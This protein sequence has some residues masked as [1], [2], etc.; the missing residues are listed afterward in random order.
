MKSNKAFW[1]ITF[2]CC[3]V[4][5][6]ASDLS[7]SKV[8]KILKKSWQYYVKTK[9]LPDGR[10]LADIDLQNLSNGSYGKELTFSESVSYILFRAVLADDQQTFNQTW[11][12]TATHLWRRNLRQVF[13]WK[14]SRWVQLPDEKRDNLF[15]WRYTPNIK[16][17]NVGGIIFAPWEPQDTQSWRDGLSVAP[18]GDQLIAGALLM[19][20]VKWGSKDASFDYLSNAK[21]IIND[22]WNLCVIKF[23]AGIIDDFESSASIKSW[24]IYASGGSRKQT[25]RIEH[26]RGFALQASVLNAQWFG[27][28]KILGNVDVA[29]YTGISFEIKSCS[30]VNIILEDTHGKKVSTEEQLENSNQWQTHQIRFSDFSGSDT[31]DWKHIKTIMFQPSEGDIALDN[32]DYIGTGSQQGRFHLLANEKGDLWLNMSYYMPFLYEGFAAVDPG[33]PW[34]ELRQD[35][36]KTVY[37]SKFSVLEN[38]KGDKFVGNG[39]LVPDWV[40]LTGKGEMTD[41]PWAKDNSIDDYLSSWDAFRTWYYTSLYYQSSHDENAYKI[42]KDKTYDF[43]ISEIAKEGYIKGG[44]AINGTQ[45]TMRG[46]SLEYPSMD[47]AYLTYFFA[48]HDDIRA[49]LMT[50]RLMKFYQS[51]GYWGDDPKDYYKQNWA[52]LGLE[53]YQNRGRSI[54]ALLVPEKLIGSQFAKN[55]E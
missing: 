34:L 47:A 36:L 45:T 1:I 19:A 51:A 13:D 17:T 31:F 53:F 5:A 25:S 14:E 44:Y 55:Y 40:A 37:D 24:F 54:Q 6:Q 39:T 16:R 20:H 11:Q 38:Q 18:D 29:N 50:Q 28:G 23:R 33:H 22:I 27:I 26:D 43:F 7:T 8:D 4:F 2:L 42:L 35:A 52:W 41:L 46:L 21:L 30:A 12:W 9:V 3:F 32:V 48:L 49:E 10:P 15:A